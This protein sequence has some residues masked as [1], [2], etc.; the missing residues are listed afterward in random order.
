MQMVDPHGPQLALGDAG[1]VVAEHVEK[2]HRATGQLAEVEA[3]RN[4]LARK[5]DEKLFEEFKEK[6]D[7]LIRRHQLQRAGRWIVRTVIFGGTVATTVL[8][9]GPGASI[10]ALEA[11]FEKFAMSQKKGERQERDRL[12]RD[13][14]EESAASHAPVGYD[15][16]WLRNRKVKRFEYLESEGHSLKS[17]TSS[18]FSGDDPKDDIDVSVDD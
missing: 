3:A 1:K 16:T 15:S 11:P 4:I 7:K 17:R 9:M 6:R 12:E 14:K 2:L 5:F 10:I 13:Y 18:D 8:I